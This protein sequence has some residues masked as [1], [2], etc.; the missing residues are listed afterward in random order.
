M[1]LVYMT[2]YYKSSTSRAMRTHRDRG[3]GKGASAGDEIHNTDCLAAACRF[4]RLSSHGSTY[5]FLF[6]IPYGFLLLGPRKL[7]GELLSWALISAHEGQHGSLSLGAL[8]VESCFFTY[9]TLE[10]V[11]TVYL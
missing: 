10:E 4:T 1:C 2:S 11:R 9:Y 3:G 6:S 8:V 7:S 5:I